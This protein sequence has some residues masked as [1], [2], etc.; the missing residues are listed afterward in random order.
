M[1]A[2]IEGIGVAFGS[3]TLTNDQLA[4]Q[5]AE[6]DFTNLIGKTGVRSRPIAAEGETALDLAER[7]CRD[8][9]NRGLLKAEQIDAL[10][11]CTETPDY[12]IPPNSCV[13]HDRLNLKTSVS[14]FDITLACSGFTYGLMLARSMIISEAA[15]R[16]LL[17]TA[18]TY[19]R[20]IHDGDRATRSLFGDGAAATIVSADCD[21]LRIL[22][23][24]TGTAGSQHTRFIVR[25]GGARLPSNEATGAEY[26]DRS[27]NRRSAE[28]IEMDGLGVLSFF[29]ST[30]P[31]AVRDL[32]AKHGLTTD[33]IDLFVFHQ[34]SAVAL[35]GI[36]R[37]LAL[38]P[39]RFVM[40]L[41]ETGNLV[42]A[43]IPVAMSRA[44]KQDRFGP[45]QRIV[46]CGFGVGLSWAT[47]LIQT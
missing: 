39:E 22:D 5:F 19:S 42:S 9:D 37:A 25:A 1:Q 7:A 35:D 17:V 14:A 20:L 43:S 27:G 41:G 24:R 26:V 6:W 21:T 38:P 16:V 4:E 34:A 15:R 2:G 40:D 44:Q 3:T 29:N 10:I 12:P 32:L 33:D 46:L 18:D 47:A 13:L 30:I 23:V 8:L 28:H 45:G 36:R 11:F 31:V